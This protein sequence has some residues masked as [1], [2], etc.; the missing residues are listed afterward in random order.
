M[1]GLLVASTHKEL[2]EILSIHYLLRN[3][4]IVLI[5]PDKT[6]ATISKGHSLRP[7]YLGYMEDDFRDVGAVLKKMVH[8][9]PAGQFMYME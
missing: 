3:M 4:K 5:L 1:V 6:E 7:R 9:R 8:Y 2:A